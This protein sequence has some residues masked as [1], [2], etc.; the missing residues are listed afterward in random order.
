MKGFFFMF[1]AV[2]ILLSTQS[3]C[4]STGI[5]VLSA[6][7]HVWG[8]IY[9][10]LYEV[11]G[12]N[13]INPQTI[14]RDYDEISSSPLSG[15]VDLS[16]FILAGLGSSS[17]A[18]KL[19]LDVNA[20]SSQAGCTVGSKEY[21]FT[22][23][24]S[25]YNLGGENDAFAELTWTFS[26][27]KTGLMLDLN[28]YIAVYGNLE[29][30]LYDLTTGT[31]LLYGDQFGNGH[32]LG[33]PFSLISQAAF[34][35]NLTVLVDTTHEYSLKMYAEAESAG[36]IDSAHISA[37]VSAVP[38]PSTLILLAFGLAGLAGVRKKFRTS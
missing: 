38:E 10:T 1:L 19:S 33:E 7:Y 35:T 14:Y 20:D 15:S 27:S 21:F 3:T 29:V 31:Q 24:L 28:G 18:G 13:Y 12:F 25:P 22:P 4:Y 34:S 5:S 37:M 32:L 11:S 26:T 16:D 8:N 30:W 2:L 9:G 6:E 17:R 23:I 36:D